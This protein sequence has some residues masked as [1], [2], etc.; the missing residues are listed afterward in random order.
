M[1]KIKKTKKIALITSALLLPVVGA[2]TIL[3]SGVASAKSDNAVK[4]YT[5]FK[6]VNNSSFDELSS[7]YA[8]NNIDG[9]KLVRSGTKATTMVIDVDKNFSTYNARPYCISTIEGGNPGKKGADNKILMINSA[10]TGNNPSSSSY[11]PSSEHEGYKSDDLKLDANSY[12]SFEVSFKTVKFS[13]VKANPFAS[14]Y[15]NGLTDNEGNEINLSYEMISSN[16]WETV[17]FFVETGDQEQNVNLELWLGTEEL[18]SFGVAFFDEVFVQQYSQNI[19]Y[20]NYYNYYYDEDNAY[21]SNNGSLTDS[22]GK[23][24]NY[25]NENPTYNDGLNRPMVS[26]CELDDTQEVVTDLNLD[27][28]DNGDKSSP[29]KWTQAEGKTQS[30]SAL[31][32]DLNLNSFNTIV[33]KNGNDYPYTGANLDYNNKK[34]LALWTNAGEAGYVG[35]TSQNIALKAHEVMKI[36]A[37]AK[38]SALDSGEFFLTVNETEKIFDSFPALKGHY[39]TL[40]TS[41][42][43]SGVGSNLYNNEYVTVEIYVQGHD[44]YDSEFNISLALGSKD[45]MAKGCVVVDNVKVE[46]AT[47]DA[48]SNATNKLKLTTTSQDQSTLTIANG[49]FNAAYAEGKEFTYPL[50]AKDWTVETAENKA[51]L[52]SGVINTHKDYFKYFTA[53]EVFKNFSNPAKDDSISNNMFM[54]TNS[55]ASYQS[56]KSGEFNITKN[57][58]YYL[59]FDYKTIK[60]LSTVDADIT[61]DIYTTSDLLIYS[62]KMNS[63]EG[64]DNHKAYLFAGENDTT[65]YAKISFGTKA[66]ACQGIAYIDNV[67]LESSAADAFATAKNKADLSNFMLNLD[68]NNTIEENISSSLAYTGVSSVENGGEGGIAKGKGNNSLGY[69]KNGEPVE[70]IDD[71]SL[72]NNVLVI[73]TKKPSTYTLTSNFKINLE[74]TSYYKLTFRILTSLPNKTEESEDDENKNKYGVNIG[75]KDLTLAENL[76]F[77]DGWTEC[78]FY[79]H[80]ENTSAL[81]T[82]LVFSLTANNQDN[83]GIAYLTDLVWTEAADEEDTTISDAFA[84]AEDNEEFGKTIFT[85]TYELQEEKPEEDTEDTTTDNKGDEETNPLSVLLYVSTAITA[86][87]VIIAIV[88]VILRKIKIKKV[89]KTRT[90]NYDRKV[91]IDANVITHEAKRIRNEEVKELEDAIAVYA[92]EMKELEDRQKANIAQSRQQNGKITKDI[93]RE[94]KSYA[95]KRSKI[96]DKLNILNE[97][98]ENVKSP[99]Y[100][101][102]LEKKVSSQ[103]LK[104]KKEA[105]RQA[106]LEAKEKAK[107]QKQDEQK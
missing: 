39:T 71:G 88:G 93:E 58:Y 25:A 86:L 36:S 77:N 4:F 46:K 10:N 1:A 5:S 57:S 84:A 97:K 23:T 35:L 85:S 24:Y 69:V 2:G 21:F 56:I 38:V 63:T 80:N 15:L 59:T 45:A 66:N 13:S 107:A 33:N 83:T 96:Q 32:F 105:Y 30:A 74:A 70:S 22:N 34:A 53:N 79:F 81:E 44:F 103:M 54:F 6:D 102:S 65:V 90:E 51:G 17:Y 55:K 52:Y 7:T 49:Y 26:L 8:S 62:V 43:V 67:K 18:S 82:N 72:K 101:I 28:E 31:V 50:T 89:N 76:V 92:S 29:S 20:E 40:S 78:T 106:E 68:P 61:L 16:D 9:W 75:L 19:F 41:A 37:L 95:S 99:E 60:T 3:L 91:T 11:T 104:A 12:Y 100:M 73:K 64:W 42:K 27:F 87:A 47:Y 14:V 48:F 98:L 94:F